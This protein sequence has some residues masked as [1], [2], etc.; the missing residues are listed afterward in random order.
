MW[1]FW[2]SE[3][4]LENKNSNVIWLH[5]QICRNNNVLPITWI[6]YL[7]RRKK[8][9]TFPSKAFKCAVLPFYNKKNPAFFTPHQPFRIISSFVKC[10]ILSQKI[11]LQFSIGLCCVFCCLSVPLDTWL[12]SSMNTVFFLNKMLLIFRSFREPLIR[13]LLGWISTKSNCKQHLAV[14]RSA[15]AGQNGTAKFRWKLFEHF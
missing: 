7:L 12:C 6:K 5:H 4:C 9:S 15:V 13:R 3:F 14:W 10:K 1:F 11:L 2:I 8:V